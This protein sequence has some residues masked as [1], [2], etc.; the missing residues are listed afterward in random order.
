M[1]EQKIEIFEIGIERLSGESFYA[2]NDK[3][4][5]YTQRAGVGSLFSETLNATIPTPD[6]S[7]FFS[8][9]EPFHL[10]TL[11]KEYG[12]TLVATL[13]WHVNI[14]TTQNEV[15]SCGINI[16]PDFKTIDESS[17][18]YSLKKAIHLLVGQDVLK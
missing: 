1:K 2:Y 15:V 4:S 5:L 8:V 7:S 17:F 3:Q 18:F 9:M 14:K 12:S 6:W 10:W 13:W 16:F 11:E